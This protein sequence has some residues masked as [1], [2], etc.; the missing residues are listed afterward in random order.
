M[1]EYQETQPFRIS[2]SALQNW[3]MCR[4]KGW[5][6]SQRKSSVI[7][8]GRNFFHGTVVDSIMRSWLKDPQPGQ[9]PLMVDSYM[10]DI[11]ANTQE[12]GDGYVKW[13][14][15]EDRNN[16]RDFCLELTK[17]L[18]PILMEK[19][20]PF[21]YEPA[22][23]FKIEIKLPDENNELQP[24]LLTGEFDLLVRDNDQ[25]FHV[26]DLKATADNSYWKKTLGQLVFYDL[27]VYAMFLETPVTSGLI[28]PMCDQR[29]LEFSFTDAD[30]RAMFGRIMAMMRAVWA[31]DHTPTDDS[32]CCYSCPVK[33]ACVKYNKPSLI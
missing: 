13:R 10:D 14:H 29:I 12:K 16:V 28:Q 6:V 32:N 15:K 20:V 27:A 2:W 26:W 1:S 8:D 18:E 19:V 17:R 24:V 9:M 4:Q 7:K 5:L 22:K 23:R 3:E 33:S 30:R 25:K 21:D 31:K 11:E